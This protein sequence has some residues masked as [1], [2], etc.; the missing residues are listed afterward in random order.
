MKVITTKQ[1]DRIEVILGVQDAKYFIDPEETKKAIIAKG[2]ILEDKTIAER[3][4]LF[5]ENAI[6]FNLLSGRGEYVEDV[7]G[8]EVKALLD[9]RE[10]KE[11][12]KRD[13]TIIKDNRNKIYWEFKNDKWK[14]TIIK[15]LDK[16]IPVGAIWEEDLSEEQKEE[17]NTQ[18]EKDR[19]KN[20]TK[21]EK[22]AEKKNALEGVIGAAANYKLKLKLEIEDLETGYYI[23]EKVKQFYDEK[24]AIIDEKYKDE[25]V[26]NANTRTTTR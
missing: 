14:D 25:E 22:E 16:E 21:E 1:I 4:V 11:L 20:L 17:I 2:I 15:K 7:E 6:Y 23:D 13:K 10:E 26:K 19:I 18:K 12:L 24:K 5:S 3:K 8:E 9:G